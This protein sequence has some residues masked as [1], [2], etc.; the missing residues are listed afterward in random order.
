MDS[1]EKNLYL[2]LYALA[3]FGLGSIIWAIVNLPPGRIDSGVVLT[4][5]LA[6]FCS[7]F[8]C[9]RLPRLDIHVSIFDS[10]LIVSVVL[11]GSQV[12][13]LLAAIAAAFTSVE[14]IR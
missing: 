6:V 1:K 7:R 5:I 9:P 10:L 3:P 12:A 2:F 13:I 14:L 4:A 8:M 11:Y